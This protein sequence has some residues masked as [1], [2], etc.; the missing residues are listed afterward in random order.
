MD[1]SEYG[2]AFILGV[3]GAV[4]KAHGNSNALAIKNAIRVAYQGVKGDLV[5]SLEMKIGEK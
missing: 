1:P 2:G 5:K 3:K 4:V